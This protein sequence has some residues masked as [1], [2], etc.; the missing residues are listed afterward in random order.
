MIW[1]LIFWASVICLAHTY[2]FFPAMLYLTV[3]NK[4]PNALQYSPGDHDLPAVSILLAAYNEEAVIA[5][6]IE[7]TFQTN[8]PA[9][10]IEFLIGSDASTDRTNAII[11]EY[12]QRFPQIRLVRFPGRTGK[13]GIINQLAEQA[14]H[15][16]LI[17]TDANVFFTQ[18]TLYHLVKHYKNPEISITGGRIVNPGAK[19]DGISFQEK[20]YLDRENMIKYY[21]GI[22]WGTMIG[23]FG[24]CYS[25][26]AADYAPVPKNY[27]M[28]DF[29]ITMNVLEKGK[30]AVN[31][32]DAIC[33]EDVSNR[34]SEEFRRKVRISIGNF[35]NLF[36]YIKLLLPWKGGLAY[37]FFSHK[38]LR[39][40]GPFFIILALA[41][42]GM[43]LEKNLFFQYTF[44]LQVGC[45]ALPILDT[46][47]KRVGIHNRL[48]R[49]VSHFYLMNLALLTGFARFIKGV[50]SN[51]WKPTQRNQ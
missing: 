16:V 41:A 15:P 9:D 22:Q 51:I 50:D 40:F 13:A 4:K 17:L 10:R 37:S 42:N 34:I 12:A 46:L 8:Y 30:K 3:R 31:E 21:E 35:Q 5:E 39:W 27:F 29:Y 18:D 38:V 11:E 28:D 43:L 23:A 2:V 47:L 33:H 26:R 24:G 6:K 49:F 25:I 36:R 7:R 48:L 44:Y 20:A 45:M 32:P 1:E 19:A 14:Q